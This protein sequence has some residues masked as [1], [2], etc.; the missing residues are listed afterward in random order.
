[1]Q[2]QQDIQ[3]PEMCG[4]RL[5]FKTASK[6]SIIIIILPRNEGTE[7]TETMQPEADL[8]AAVSR[9]GK[10]M[11]VPQSSVHLKEKFGDGVYRSPWN[12]EH[13]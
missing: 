13:F 9:A 2:Q 8:W 7:R 1:M 12:K 4:N 10:T 6:I 5:C 3:N 11:Q